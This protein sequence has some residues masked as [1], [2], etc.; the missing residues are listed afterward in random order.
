MFDFK[1]VFE[2]WVLMNNSTGEYASTAFDTLEECLKE[3]KEL[4]LADKNGTIVPV[5]LTGEMMVPTAH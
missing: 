4:I 2:R 5:K 3:N 1:K